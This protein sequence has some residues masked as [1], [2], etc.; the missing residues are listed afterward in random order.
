MRKRGIILLAELVLGLLIVSCLVMYYGSNEAVET[1][2]GLR[3]SDSQ[4]SRISEKIKT[5][6]DEIMEEIIANRKPTVVIDAG[7]G[8][9][10]PGCVVGRTMEKDINLLIALALK[11][12]LEERG[13][14]VIMTRTGDIDISLTNRTNFAQPLFADYFVSIH[15]NAYTADRSIRGFQCFYF[16]SEQGKKLSDEITGLVKAQGIKIRKAQETGF[17][18]LRESG[19]PAILIETGYLTNSSERKALLSKDY[20]RNM[21]VLIAEGIDK[22]LQS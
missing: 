4:G 14:G 8:G 7:H 20:Q 22:V 17:Q 15:C 5:G 1:V 21:A 19:V 11:E 3:K 12:E 18:V 2:G 13:I 9:N 10:Q 6:F 16:R